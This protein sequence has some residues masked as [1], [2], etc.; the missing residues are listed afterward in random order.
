M[1]SF[2]VLPAVVLVLSSVMLPGFL[3]DVG[4]LTVDWRQHSA[5][6]CRQGDVLFLSWRVPV[7]AIAPILADSQYTAYVIDADN[8]QIEPQC[9]VEIVLPTEDSDDSI[10]EALVLCAI[11]PRTTK[12]LPAGMYHLAIELASSEATLVSSQTQV[13]VVAELQTRGSG[14][15]MRLAEMFRIA[16]TKRAN[17]ILGQAINHMGV[18]PAPSSLCMQRYQAWQTQSELPGSPD[19]QDPQSKV[20]EFEMSLRAQQS[21]SADSH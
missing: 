6:S 1:K 13:H 21:S 8:A 5:D 7:D 16:G 20:F 18:R 15:R 17:S 2:K 14:H 3:R 11:R 9:P 19:Q 4:T 10:K 12:Q